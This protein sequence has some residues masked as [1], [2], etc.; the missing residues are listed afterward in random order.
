M[1]HRIILT[2]SLLPYFMII[3]YLTL[4]GKSEIPPRFFQPIISEWRFLLCKR[5]TSVRSKT[6]LS[7]ERP[8]PVFLLFR[9]VHQLDRLPVCDVP[10]LPL[11]EDAI[12]HAGCAEQPY[13]TSMQGSERAPADVCLL[14]EENGRRLAITGRSG[15]QVF[16]QIQRQSPITHLHDVRIHRRLRCL[17][18]ERGKGR[19]VPPGCLLPPERIRDHLDA[20]QGAR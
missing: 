11:A 8:S 10:H 3:P 2:I 5:P 16:D 4:A 6:A 19:P 14:C 17:P 9:L 1:L 7:L 13:M 20:P 15:K 18:R 12:Q